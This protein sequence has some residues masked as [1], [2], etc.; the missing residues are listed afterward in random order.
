[1]Q[2]EYFIAGRLRHKDEIQKVVDILRDAGKSY[3]CFL[4]NEYVGESVQFTKD[5]N[6][7]EAMKQFE[8]IPDWRNDETVKKIFEND[9]NALKASEKFVLVIPA[10]KSGHIEAGTA[11]GLGKP[12]YAVGE[13][14]E[15]ESLYLIF[16]EMF[17][18]VSKFKEFVEVN[19]G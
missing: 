9:M 4:D 10:G 7:E 13:Q 17:P 3:Y 14:I 19:N 18:T 15:T 16:N 8:Q 1:M 5:K 6:P 2:Y 11:Y 12:C